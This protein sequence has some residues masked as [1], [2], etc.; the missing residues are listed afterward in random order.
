MVRNVLEIAELFYNKQY[1]VRKIIFWGEKA[2]EF[3]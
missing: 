2:L 3:V 1:N